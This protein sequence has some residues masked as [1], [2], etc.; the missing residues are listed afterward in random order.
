MRRK[1]AGALRATVA[2]ALSAA[3]VLGVLVALSHLV[4]PKNNQAEFGQIDASAHGVAGERPNSIDV[5]F[6]GDSEAYS[7]FSPLDLWHA[8]GITSYVVATSSQK[9]PYTRSLLAY[10]LA[11]QSPRVVVLDANCL[12]RSFSLG[13]ALVRAIQD[14]L[15]VFEYHNRWKSLTLEDVVG[16]VRTTWSDELKGFHLSAKVDPADASGYQTPTD[17]VASMPALSMAYLRDIARTCADRGARLVL[18]STPST[19]N[20]D[21]AKHNRVRLV[22]EELGVDYVDLNMGD[23]RVDIDWSTDTRDAGDHLNLSGARKVTAR[24]GELLSGRYGLEGHR[25][26]PAFDSWDEA[27]SR[28]EFSTEGIPMG[29]VVTIFGTGAEMNNGAVITNEETK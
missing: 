2:V 20:W 28:Y 23:E 11:R 26:D 9:L 19:K 21:M 16:T 13:D 4:M 15:P 8:R 17:R 24:M 22:A 6:M 10:A 29:A 3:F 27:Y 7:S 1:L 25:G 12:F 14:A 5:L 18:V